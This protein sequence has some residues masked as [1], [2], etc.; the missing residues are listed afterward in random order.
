MRESCRRSLKSQS[1]M[2]FDALIQEYADGNAPVIEGGVRSA[3]INDTVAWTVVSGSSGGL[4][5]HSHAWHLFSSGLSKQV[6][7]ELTECTFLLHY[8]TPMLAWRN[9]DD[10]EFPLDDG[11]KQ[12]VPYLVSCGRVSATDQ[13]G[14][15]KACEA[16]GFELRFVRSKQRFDQMVKR[17]SKEEQP[18]EYWSHPHSKCMVLDASGR[19]LNRE[20]NIVHI[21]GARC[22]VIDLPGGLR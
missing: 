17:L 18:A 3:R 10:G 13:R 5:P 9:Y 14:F 4:R 8:G 16:L 12:R 15:H 7:E 2:S 21:C 6:D 22:H 1:R 19:V 11:G 20:H